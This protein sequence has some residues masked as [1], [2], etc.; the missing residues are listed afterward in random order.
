[1]ARKLVF[2]VFGLLAS[3]GCASLKSTT[4]D[5]S[6]VA[7]DMCEVV[8]MRR[9]EVLAQA[10]QQKLSP[11]DVAKALCAVN[12]VVRPFLQG[13]HR[14]GAHAV[15]AAHRLGKLRPAPTPEPDTSE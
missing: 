1:M 6:D 13:A 10:K 15:V 9:P 12:D 11:A 3:T 4:R 8:L 5:I 7:H 14:A 2:V